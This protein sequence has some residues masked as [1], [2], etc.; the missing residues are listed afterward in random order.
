M[1]GSGP[2][3]IIDTKVAAQA[4]DAR[5]NPIPLVGYWAFEDATGTPKVSP[6]ALTT[7]VTTLTLP[8]SCIG[9]SIYAESDDILFGDNTNLTGTTGQ[10]TGKGSDIIPEGTK[11]FIPLTGM[12]TLKLRARNDNATA[13]IKYGFAGSAS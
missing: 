7:G 3:T 1:P 5:G 9:V 6:V 8:T 13:F 12:T 10:T 4:L 11:E 2:S